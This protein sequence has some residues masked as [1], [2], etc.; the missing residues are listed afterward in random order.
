[1]GDYLREEICPRLGADAYIGVTQEQMKEMADLTVSVGLKMPTPNGVS[2]DTH[3]VG[4]HTMLVCERERAHE[5]VHLIHIGSDSVTYN[6]DACIW[7][8]THTLVHT[9]ITIVT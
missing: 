6:M 4:C 1:M 2:S 9:T 3:I 7:P 5:P 8:G